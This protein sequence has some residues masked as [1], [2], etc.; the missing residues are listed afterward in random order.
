MQFSPT[1]VA[2]L[3]PPLLALLLLLT[4][5]P[6]ALWLQAGPLA[7]LPGAGQR[8]LTVAASVGLLATSLLAAPL[9]TALLGWPRIPGRFD[10][11]P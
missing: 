7:E 1:D 3:L 11:H 2:R 8:A 10:V 4:G 5:L 9:Q 6:V